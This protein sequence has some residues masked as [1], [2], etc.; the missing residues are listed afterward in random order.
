L[1]TAYRAR[2]RRLSPPRTP[3]IPAAI[4]ARMWLAPTLALLASSADVA[5]ELPEHELAFRFP[6]LEDPQ[7]VDTTG[8]EQIRGLWTGRVG[9]SAVELRLSI[10]GRAELGIDRP[11][12]VVAITEQHHEW[13]R[14]S[15][16]ERGEASP[17]PAF[18]FQ[19]QRAVGG[20]YGYVPYAFLGVHTTYVETKPAEQMLCLGGVLTKDAWSIELS[21]EPALGPDELAAVTDSLLASVTYGGDVQDPNWTDEE[22]LARWQRDAPE[23]A[24]PDLVPLR[25]DHYLILSNCGKGT[26]KKFGKKMEECYQSIREVFPFETVEGERL[27]PVFLFRTAEQYYAFGVKSVGWTDAQARA[28][29]GVAWRDFY[30]TYY[31]APNDPVHIHEA[32]HQI[33]ANRLRAT[34]GGSWFQEGVAEYM[35]TSENDRK[36]FKRIVK[37]ER[38]V[39]LARFFVIPSLLQ[40]SGG[41]RLDGTNEATEGYL[42]AACMIEFLRESDWSKDRF[43]DVVR[44]VGRVPRGDLA[45]I[46]AALGRVLGT[47]LAGLEERFLDYWESRR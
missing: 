17:G 2:L 27:L 6:A 22:L 47:D 15:A 34:G 31:E 21:A 32:T 7:P 37:D 24:V 28:S 5:L 16:V 25:T 13:L 14:T 40:S 11:A 41:T 23:D 36:A 43:Q 12:D 30:A 46:E 45:E 44:E 9:R 29:K 8:N 18:R 33:F 3:A 10:Y 42:Q 4:L 1:R 20:V 19:E 35:S 39:P 26:M 38:A